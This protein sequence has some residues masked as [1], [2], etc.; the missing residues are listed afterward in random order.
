M[1]IEGDRMKEE[2]GWRLPAEDKAHVYTQGGWGQTKHHILRSACSKNC[3]EFGVE[4]ELR[5]EVRELNRRQFMNGSR[6]R[7]EQWSLCWEQREANEG[8]HMEG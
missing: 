5:Y 6:A 1:C 7:L 4:H 8:D 2:V 3:Q